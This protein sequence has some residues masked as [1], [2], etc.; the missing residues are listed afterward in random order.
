M[1]FGVKSDNHIGSWLLVKEGVYVE[2]AE[3]CGMERGSLVS[4]LFESTSILTSLVP[5]AREWNHRLVSPPPLP[6]RLPPSPSPA[7][8][9]STDVSQDGE[10]ITSEN[11]LVKDDNAFLWERERVCVCRGRI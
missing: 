9:Y 3:W 7:P 6:F 11:M 2:N 1:K 5:S 10:E 4:T 8:N